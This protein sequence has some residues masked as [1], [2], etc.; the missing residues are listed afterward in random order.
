M[1]KRA[2]SLL[3]CLV[4]VAGLLPLALI[5]CSK[6]EIIRRETSSMTY[7]FTNYSVIPT[8]GKTVGKTINYIRMDSFSNN[9]LFMVV[10]LQG[11]VNKDDPCIYVI[12]DEMVEGIE[13]INASEYWFDKLDETYTGEEAFEKTEYVDPYRMLA[14]FADRIEGA[15][16]YHERLVDA[17]NTSRSSYGSRYADMAVLN[18]TVMMA[19]KYNSVALTYEQ[20]NKL[21]SEYGV[22][23]PVKGDTTLFMERDEDGNVSDNRGSREVWARVYLYA[24]NEFKDFNKKAL[25]HL[26]G[27][28]A[29]TIDYFI[30][31]DIFVYNRI[32]TADA[33]EEERAIE[34]AIVNFSDPNTPVFGCWYL[35]ADEGTLVPYLTE[36]YK[37]FVVNYETFNWSW[38]TALPEEEFKPSEKEEK[39]ILDESK[40]YI[41][42]T[43]SEGDN[44]SYVN[45]RMPVIFDN[46]PRGE[47]DDYPVGWTIAP[48]VLETNPN[49]IRYY[50]ENMREGD[51]W[52]VPESG[53]DYVYHCPPEE[54]QDE[55]FAL[56]DEYLGRM[57]GGVMRILNVDL[58][59]PLPYLEK[60]ENV[61]GLA[62][63]YYNT[64]NTYYNS[65]LSNFMFRGKPVFLNFSGADIMTLNQC[66]SQSPGFYSVSLNG[67]SQDCGSIKSAMELLGDNFVCVTPNQLV[68]LYKQKYDGEFTD[69]SSADFETCMTREEMGFL[70]EASDYASYDSISK[71]RIVEEKNY[72]I[73]KFDFNEAAE[74]ALLKL[75]LDGEYQIEVS[76]DYLNWH[77]LAR[78][79][80]TSRTDK[81]F[82][83]SKYLGDGPVYV[84]IGD[85]TVKDAGGVKLYRIGVTTD[86][87]GGSGFE[88]DAFGEELY[89]LKGGKNSGEGRTGTFTYSFTFDENVT[90]GDLAVL[91]GGDAL[92][93]EISGDN[94]NFRNIELTRQANS[95]YGRLEGLS[96]KTYLRFTAAEPVEKIKFTPSSD[97]VTQL[98]FSPVT[99]GASKAMLISLDDTT[100]VETGFNSNRQVKEENAMIFRFKADERITSAALNL[101][102]S[103]LYKLEISNDNRTYRTLAAVA[104]GETVAD[105]YKADIT[106]YAAGGKEIYLKI[107]LSEQLP[108]KSV[109]L[110]KLRLLTDLTEDW[111][112]EKI[113][114]ERDEDAIVSVESKGRDGDTDYGFENTDSFEYYLLDKTLTS[115][116]SNSIYM[117][118]YAIPRRILSSDP[119]DQ[120]VYKFDF[121]DDL[122]WEGLGLSKTTVER[123][124]ISIYILNGFNISVSNDGENWTELY[125]TNDPAVSMGSNA[126]YY[127]FTLDDFVGEG[128]NVVYLRF[129]L[130]NVHQA[131]KTH[132]GQWESIKFYFN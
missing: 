67:W 65:E 10:S 46:D 30:A 54:S 131:D 74:K 19:A 94:K 128:R 120:V 98:N 27:N 52:A 16:L 121:T 13:G 63:G 9:D 25:G 100:T 124:R 57:G 86:V 24:L 113:D 3:L 129:T 119:N 61:R 22:E 110:Y 68:D 59:D 55:Y 73:Y 60:M 31:N 77:V 83:L 112:Y 118:N 109:K 116:Y 33:T 14:D 18:L 106:E 6:N 5:G 11:N 123:F 32:F 51:S 89:L 75:S 125:D 104:A 103:G 122:F 96:G 108:G 41:A 99:N 2:L 84:R 82:D 26:A 35:Q 66:E 42:F 127:D 132:V 107:S 62:V 44:N 69:I 12:H 76:T 80:V 81:S 72:L 20:Y 58:T 71:C 21:K 64:G 87:I 91:G 28:Q 56:S 126:R 105:V 17:V 39:I 23:L 117:H 7:D 114:S 95:V 115:E 70:W 43:F 4:F 93:V 15:V 85:P 50:R 47:N 101:T 29:A 111:L 78:G 45:M 88:A 97:G 37:F 130:S 38:T 102:I 40:N 92:K 34:D 36:N 49:I 79:E 48:T 8:T 90:S 1:I 53:V